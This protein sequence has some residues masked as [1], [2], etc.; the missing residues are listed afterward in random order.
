[1]TVLKYHL[2]METR[3]GNLTERKN[4]FFL[5][6]FF[7]LAAVLVVTFCFFISTVTYPQKS[8]P[9]RKEEKNYHIVV[10]GGYENELFLTQVYEGAKNLSPMYNALVELYVP[11]SQAEDVLLQSLFDYAT[12]VN[13]DGIIAYIDSIDAKIEVPKRID[14]SEIPLVTTGMYAP[15]IHSV[16]Y[17]GNS[18]WE[19]GRK[20]AEETVEM[21]HKK[22]RAFL[23]SQNLVTNP[24][25][26]NL[27]NSV[28][29]TLRGYDEI[30][31]T[32]LKQL[33]QAVIDSEIDIKELKETEETLL[34]VCLS[35][36]DT[37]MT[38]QSLVELG[39]DKNP[40]I[41]LIGFGGNETCQLYL[42]KGIIKELIAVDPI[43]IGMASIKELF[44]YRNNGYANSYIAADVQ[45]TRSVQ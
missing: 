5:I 33:G 18:Y 36:E 34:F 3:R 22:G 7:L 1:M 13:A 10:L 4:P 30:D 38:A 17:I 11:K 42:R 37:I 8:E 16:S 23:I 14:G 2:L 25:Y 26:S 43:K 40:H 24:Y 35:E 28:R 44:E 41:K 20:I 45:I 9:S 12:F 21:L 29:D 15:A 39:L 19:L 32:V 31:Y 6:L 27:M